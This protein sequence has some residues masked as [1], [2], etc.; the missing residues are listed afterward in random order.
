MPAATT[1]LLLLHSCVPLRFGTPLVPIISRCAR[2]RLR[3]R[4]IY[5]QSLLS[6][7]ISHQKAVLFSQNKPA[8]SNQPAVLF[9]QN[10][11]APAINHQPTEQAAYGLLSVSGLIVVFCIGVRT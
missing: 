2:L 9:S 7:L 10:K 6:W 3:R 4:S 8:T 5:L 11:A 1:I